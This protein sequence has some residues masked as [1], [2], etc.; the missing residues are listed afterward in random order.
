MQT[1]AKPEPPMWKSGMATRPTDSVSKPQW[2]PTDSSAANW[3][4]VSTTPLAMPVV[5]EV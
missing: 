3:V 1:S 5:P 4:W 2:P